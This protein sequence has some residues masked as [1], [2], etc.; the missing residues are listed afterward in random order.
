L[1]ACWQL[2]RVA[3]HPK[4]MISSWVLQRSGRVVQH[5]GRLLGCFIAWLVIA[6]WDVSWHGL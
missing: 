5:R 1:L 2:R 3:K 6:S 4:R